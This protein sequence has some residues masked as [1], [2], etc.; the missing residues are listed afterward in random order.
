M[1]VVAPLTH[2]QQREN[3]M[4]SSQ[5]RQPPP[6]RAPESSTKVEVPREAA[7]RRCIS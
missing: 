3:S 5:L 1:S 4:P 2:P 6:E 7:S